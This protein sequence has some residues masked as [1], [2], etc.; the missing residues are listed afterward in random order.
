MSLIYLA[1]LNIA[2]SSG[3]ATTL[4]FTS[5]KTLSVSGQS[6]IAKIAQ[7][8]FYGQ[9]ISIDS[10]IGGAISPSIGEL[11]LTNTKRD[12]DSYKG[13]IFE[14][15]LLYLYTY[16]TVAQTKVL[17][18]TQTIEQASFEWD[19]VSIRLQ[20]RST[21]LEKPLQTV[22]YGGT[23][24][25][26]D[27]V[28]GVS[29]LK[30]KYKPLIF[31]RVAN[32]SPVMVNS[33]KLIYQVSSRPV[34]QIVSV[35]SNGNY[36]TP[37]NTSPTTFAEFTAEVNPAESGKFVFF[38]DAANGTLIRL[39]MNFGTIT[40]TSWDNISALSNTPAQII[41]DV[42][43]YAG[44]TSTDWIESD[45]TTLDSI[46]AD[47]IGIVLSDGQTTSSVLTDICSSIGVWWGFDANNKFRLY[48]FG[49]SATPL[50]TLQ[51]LSGTSPYGITS[52]EI[53]NASVNGK[54]VPAKEVIVNYDKNWTVQDKANL[55]G[56]MTVKYP[57]RVNW[58][59][60]EYRKVNAVN[61]TTLT[62]YPES[63]VFEYTTLLNGS[64]A[65]TAEANRVKDLLSVKRFTISA[66]ARLSTSD[67]KSLYIGA[68]IKVTIPRYDLS[69]GVNFIITS[70]EVDYYNS[71]VNLTLWG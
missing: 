37:M 36:I 41:K 48:Y 5:G 56:I 39:G 69:E 1:E 71:T 30:G 16:D 65:A 3:V 25:L 61:S 46:I 52:F 11:V 50:M 45:F 12:L 53:S 68:T 38:S 19:R 15:K 44:L 17:I 10:S 33:S 55:A 27:G 60:E 18:L 42:L 26:P 57:D 70:M 32:I 7:P 13:Y 62:N 2:T 9:S 8:A 66:T 23:N 34:E 58:L 59:G 22:K 29:D 67:L 63:Q 35:M 49:F 64:I 43:L 21:L 20:N 28:D 51:T 54:A 24:T 14:G 6:Y 47:N 31:G 40:C 4:Y